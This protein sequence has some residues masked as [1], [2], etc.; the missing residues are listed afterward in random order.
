MAAVI[1]SHIWAGKMVH[2]TYTD[3]VAEALKDGIALS[4]I[5]AGIANAPAVKEVRVLRTSCK[6]IIAGENANKFAVR[7]ILRYV[8]V[9]A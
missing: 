4:T 3:V 8:P 7:A 2:A 1:K 6:K 5:T 9:A